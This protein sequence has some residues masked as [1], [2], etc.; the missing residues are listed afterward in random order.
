MPQ[1]IDIKNFKCVPLDILKNI[2]KD[3]KLQVDITPEDVSLASMKDQQEQSIAA[4]GPIAG[5]KAFSA[6]EM[7]NFLVYIVVAF[8]VLILVVI[9]FYGGLNLRTYGLSAFALPE[10]LRSL[11]IIAL[12]ALIFGALGF[13]VGRFT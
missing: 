12:V 1:E 6:D 10:S 13:V 2:T 11:P 8:A 7:E 3:N 4:T 5:S 9:L